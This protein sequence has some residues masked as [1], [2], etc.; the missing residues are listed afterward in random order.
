MYSSI[1]RDVCQD[2]ILDAATSHLVL[3]QYV[4]AK[5]LTLEKIKIY[6]H[7]L[8]FK[9]KRFLKFEFKSKK[10]ETLFQLVS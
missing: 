9:I 5:R 8:A 10:F 7:E 1:E 2:K 6:V 4:D 3:L